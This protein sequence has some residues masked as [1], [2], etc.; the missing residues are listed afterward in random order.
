MRLHLLWV[1]LLLHPVAPP[2]L[3]GELSEVASRPTTAPANAGDSR[4]D[5]FLPPAPAGKRWKL[6]WHDEFDGTTLDESKWE[7]PPDAPRRD[8]W[9]VRRAV[10]LDGKGHLVMR[11]LEE[12]GK[13]LTGCVRTRGKFEHAFG[14]YAARIRLQRQ[15]GHWPAFW[16][17]GSGVNRVGDEGR[18]GTEIDIMEKPW[19]DDRVH[20]ALHWDGYGEHHKSA[21]H[22]PRVPGVMEGFHVFSLLWTPEGYVFYVD[23]RE[24]WRTRAG[25]VCQVPLFIKISDEV[26]KWAGDITTAQLPDEFLV[27]YVRVYDL[28]DAG[29]AGEARPDAGIVAQPPPAVAQRQPRAAGPQAY[30]PAVRTFADNVPRLGHDVYGPGPTPLFVDGLNVDTHEPAVWKL[31]SQYI[32]SWNMSPEWILSNLASQQNLFR[33]LAALTELTGEARYR[34]AAEEAI[35]YAFDHLQHENGLLFWGGHAAWNLASKEPVGEGR[36]GPVAGKHEL[37]SSYPFYELMWEVDPDATRR[38]IEAFWSNHILRWDILDM[39]RHGR[40]RPILDDLWEHEYPFAPVPFAGQGLTFMNSG[41]DL[42]YAGAMLFHFI[43]DERPLIWAKRLA[44]RYVEARHPQTGLGGDNYSTLTLDRMTQ[45]FGEEFGDRFTEAT[46]TSLYGNRYNRSA[47][48]QLKLAERLGPVGSEF[49]RWAVEDLTAY[50][51]HTYDSADNTFWATLID[52]TKLSP[53]DIK[54]KGYVET[55]WLEKRPASA[56]HFWAYALAYRLT[57]DELMW[58]TAGQIAAGL[59]LGDIGSDPASRPQLDLETSWTDADTIFA[60]LE[61]HS[62]T[63]HDAFLELAR[64]IGDNLLAKEF[65][66]GFFVPSRDHLFSRFDTATPL[67]LLHLEVALRRLPAR[68]PEYLAGRAF[69]HCAFEGHGRTYDN[70]AIFARLRE[71]HAPAPG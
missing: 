42:F 63:G 70:Q 54:R 51:Q 46:V 55:R 41:S 28:V 48:C 1:A 56:L 31:A 7:C 49:K 22:T 15:P 14:Y 43:G 12:D 71:P 52:G 37:K 23:G 9:W 39:D 25:G 10:E 36:S 24:T 66:K 44:R 8:G 62:A 17:M 30:L 20:H 27:D 65:H 61:L 50:A 2:A 40:Y 35:R 59:G 53:A 26:G 45:Q 69:F 29:A 47:I 13:Y 34:Q 11:C 3:A 67:A 18:D 32:D 64:R 38:F 60:L 16:L 6:I 68:L 57:G 33:T 5:P 4:T 21:A 58:R 19:L